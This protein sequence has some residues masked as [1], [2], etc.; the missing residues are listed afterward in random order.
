MINDFIELLEHI[1]PVVL[2]VIG[3]RACVHFMM[4]VIRG[5]IDIPDI[6]SFKKDKSMK[7]DEFPDDESEPIGF[8]IKNLKR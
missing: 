1:F 5:G 8:V 7:P 6:E 4:N 2:T 3:I